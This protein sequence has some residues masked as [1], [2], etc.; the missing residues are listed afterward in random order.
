LSKA[1]YMKTILRSARHHHHHHHI[2][3]GWLAVLRP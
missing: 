2:L 3:T 1:S